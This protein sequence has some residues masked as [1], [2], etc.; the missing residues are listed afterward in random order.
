[1]C[2]VCMIANLHFSAV[3][4]H[5]RINS[6]RFMAASFYMKP[7]TPNASGWQEGPALLLKSRVTP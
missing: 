6:N 4:D 7:Q 1:M 3:W 2:Y 5:I